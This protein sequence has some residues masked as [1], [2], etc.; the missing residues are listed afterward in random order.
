MRE[1]VYRLFTTPEGCHGLIMYYPSTRTRSPL[2]C[3][4]I[5]HEG[6]TYVPYTG[7]VVAPYKHNVTADRPVGIYMEYRAL[8]KAS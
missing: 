7:E 5:I 3:S 2:D 4:S 6:R 1:H 8:H